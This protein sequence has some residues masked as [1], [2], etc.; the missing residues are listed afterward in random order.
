MECYKVG[1][2]LI[3]W[4]NIQP[5]DWK[6]PDKL[7]RF[8]E[9]HAEPVHWCV[10]LYVI[11]SRHESTKFTLFEVMFNRITSLLIRNQFS[12][13][14]PMVTLT[15]PICTTKFSMPGYQCLQYCLVWSSWCFCQ[16]IANL[17]GEAKLRWGKNCRCF[18]WAIPVHIPTGADYYLVAF[19]STLLEFCSYLKKGSSCNDHW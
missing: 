7:G 18:D 5:D 3:G 19:A 15:V 16:K 11:L 17:E 12:Q 2:S 6:H 10:C 8:Q 1:H 4:W 9:E 13:L 14:L